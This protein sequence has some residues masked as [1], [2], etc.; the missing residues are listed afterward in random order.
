MSFSSRSNIGYSAPSMSIFTTTQS[1]GVNDLFSH[2]TKSIAGT[3]C[4]LY[5][6]AD[7][8]NFAALM[9]EPSLGRNVLHGRLEEVLST[10]AIFVGAAVLSQ[11][12]R[13]QCDL[14]DP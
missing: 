14:N 13:L 5:L 9:V 4:A 1:A 2:A 8:A 6:R 7:V 12:H 11:A 10:L 3:F